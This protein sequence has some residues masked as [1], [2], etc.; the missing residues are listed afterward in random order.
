VDRYAARNVSLELVMVRIAVLGP[1][2]GP[3]KTLANQ[4]RDSRVIKGEAL[5]WFE[6]R[7]P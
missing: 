2:S 3:K 4:P 1:R 6:E 7:E 5:G